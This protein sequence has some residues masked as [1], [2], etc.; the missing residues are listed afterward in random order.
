M[1]H[2]LPICCLKL[3]QQQVDYVA[4]LP[5]VVVASNGPLSETISQPH[6][7]GDTCIIAMHQLCIRRTTGC[8]QRANFSFLFNICM[9]W[10][11]SQW[12]FSNGWYVQEN[13]HKNRIKN[14]I[15]VCSTATSTLFW[16]RSAAQLFHMSR[17]CVIKKT[18][19]SWKTCHIT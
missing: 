7:F 6:C 13:P 8:K 9:L 16:R 4:R 1:I 17:S 14:G 15:C 3:Q 19:E 11:W 12:C 10:G 5:L 18:E 2:L